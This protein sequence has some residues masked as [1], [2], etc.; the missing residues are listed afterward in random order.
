MNPEKLM[1]NT[2]WTN[3]SSPKVLTEIQQR[4]P[5][6]CIF[7]TLLLKLCGGNYNQVFVANILFQCTPQGP[8]QQGGPTEF[9]P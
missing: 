7:T 5:V 6:I 4:V 8:F 9:I 2:V 1:I 3:Y